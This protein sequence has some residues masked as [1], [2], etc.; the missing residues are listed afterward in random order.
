[1]FMP[2]KASLIK[3]GGTPSADALLQKEV[4]CNGTWVRDM[5]VSLGFKCRLCTY[6]PFDL[7]QISFL[8]L[9]LF[10]YKMRMIISSYRVVAMNTWDYIVICLA[11]YTYKCQFPCSCEQWAN[12][13]YCELFQVASLNN[14]PCFSAWSLISSNSNL[15][16]ASLY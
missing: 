13:R 7:G 8:S 5:T 4:W 11:H 16:V 2:W 1:M 9:R 14:I 12:A 15:I 3:S 10:S 6:C